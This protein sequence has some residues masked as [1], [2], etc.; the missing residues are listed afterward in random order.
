MP[1]SL[2]NCFSKTGAVF[3]ITPKP[4]R[5]SSSLPCSSQISWISLPPPSQ[6]HGSLGHAVAVAPEDL[7]LYTSLQVGAVR[8]TVIV[9]LRI[10]PHPETMELLNLSPDRTPLPAGENAT[11]SGLPP[12]PWL[13]SHSIFSVRG[14]PYTPF[15]TTFF[16]LLGVHLTPHIVSALNFDQELVLNGCRFPSN[17]LCIRTSSQD[18]PLSAFPRCH[19][20]RR[21]HPLCSCQPSIHNPQE[22]TQ[23]V[24]HSGWS[25]GLG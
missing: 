4:R 2:P 6:T 24:L 7:A 17:L 23:G 13:H 5:A 22:A 19:H 3:K 12:P 8:N 1:L 20:P 21:Y 14:E 25:R 9:P 10:A 18:F 15:V 11:F 16:L